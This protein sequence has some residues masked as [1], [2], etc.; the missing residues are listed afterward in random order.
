MF[1]YVRRIFHKF[2]ETSTWNISHLIY[3]LIFNILP[4][5]LNLLKGTKKL[6]S[7]TLE[8]SYSN[9]SQI[10]VRDPSTR[11]LYVKL[12]WLEQLETAFATRNN[13]V[14]EH[15]GLFVLYIPEIWRN[16]VKILRRSRAC[17]LSAMDKGKS[18]N[19]GRGISYRCPFVHRNNRRLTHPCQKL[20]EITNL[21]V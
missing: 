20:P 15:S 14:A 16:L 12:V 19:W 10:I 18:A 5:I 1:N 6:R 2:K 13:A 9:Y 17:W 3:K 4:N 21:D 8:S 7:E 11:Y